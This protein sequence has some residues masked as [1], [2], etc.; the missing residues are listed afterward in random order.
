MSAHAVEA[1]F[2]EIYA[3]NFRRLTG[4]IKWH[5]PA[6]LASQAED[7]AQAAFISLL[8]HMRKGRPVEKPY[9]LLMKMAQRKIWDHQAL[10]SAQ[11]AFTTDLNDPAS[12]ALDGLTEHRYAAGDPV[13][14]MIAAELET[15]YGRMTEASEQWRS[16]HNKLGT[17]KPRTVDSS[18]CKATLRRAEWRE[19]RRADTRRQ[20]DEALIEF[21]EA[22]RVVGQLRGE[23]EQ[24]GGCWKSCS[25]WPPPRHCGGKRLEGVASDPT[26]KECSKGHCL[27]DLE[28]VGFLADGTRVCR[29]CRNVRN[30]GRQKVGAAS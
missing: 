10:H 15:A 30:D 23:L 9:G 3:E 27:K 21:Q 14:A 29:E 20:R 24:A 1:Q 2:N 28:R 22:C 12:I 4:W 8:E 13:L 7:F 25:G 6:S 26:S 16:L 19:A 17:M 5:L 11:H 18:T